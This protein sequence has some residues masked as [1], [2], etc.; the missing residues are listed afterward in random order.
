ML[1]NNNI[2]IIARW[3]FS[4]ACAYFRIAVSNFF[5]DFFFRTDIQ[6]GLV[7]PCIFN[8]FGYKSISPFLLFLLCICLFVPVDWSSLFIAL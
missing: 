5:K 2:Q 6:F 3:V 8:F 7:L 4:A 1:Y